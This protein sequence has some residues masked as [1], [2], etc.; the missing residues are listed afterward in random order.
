MSIRSL[1]KLQHDSDAAQLGSVTNDSTATLGIKDKEQARVIGASKGQG[2]RLESTSEG[3]GIT[4]ERA[5]IRPG[6]NF[7]SGTIEHKPFL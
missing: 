3:S 4:K 1:K 2:E 6:V 7:D 5:W